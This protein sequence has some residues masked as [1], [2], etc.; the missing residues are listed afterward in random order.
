[1]SGKTA[2]KPRKAAQNPIK[3]V[4]NEVSVVPLDTKTIKDG[5]REVTVIPATEF[6]MLVKSRRGRPTKYRPMFCE[7]IINYF[8]NSNPVVAIVDDP[9]GKGG[10][11][12][13]LE[14]LRVPTINGFA[15]RIGVNQDTLYEW[16]AK[17]EEFSEALARAQALNRAIVEELGLAGRLGKGLAELYFI[18]HLNYKDSR[19]I[20]VTSDGAPLPTPITALQLNV[21]N[22]QAPAL[23]E[24]TN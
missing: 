11:Q 12:T 15:A 5:N 3:T 10:S 24:Q 2:T 7:M 17:H 21:N 1:M 18:N 6:K 22:Q 23:P 19:H 14:T 16:A 20:D 13:R 4:E 9:G 8:E